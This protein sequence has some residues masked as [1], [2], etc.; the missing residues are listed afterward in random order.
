MNN[1]NEKIN[2]KNLN[3]L[4]QTARVILKLLLI[5]AICGIVIFGFVFL[6]KTQIINIL[7][8]VLSICSPLFIGLMI[9]WLFEPMIK[10]L[11]KRKLSRQLSTTIVYVL[12]IL[13]L[14]LLLVLV[15]P[16]FISQVKELIGQVPGY[17]V[18][19]KDFIGNF[20]AK[21][22]DSEIDINAIQNNVIAQVE[23]V[24]NNITSNSLSGI[25]DT[26]TKIISSGAVVALG[27]LIGFY[28]SLDFDKLT[29][30]INSWIPIKYKKDTGKVFDELNSM[31][32]GYV[33][34][35]LFTSLAVA[36]FTFIGLIISGIS[37]PL[38]FAIFCGI[39]NII[40]YFGPYIG[41][42]PTVLVGFSISPMCGIICAVTIILVQFID[43]NI[44]HPIVV[45]KATDIHP[46]TIVIGLLVFEYYFGIVGMILATPI[47]GAFK[48][49]FNFFN[50]KYHFIA[51]IKSPKKEEKV[52]EKL[53]E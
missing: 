1:K 26:V 2:Y 17:L 48:I 40:P 5:L 24:A 51:M 53:D 19:I 52:L 42:I 45:G 27:V 33:S 47:I 41:G 32:R 34:G 15:V 22:Q 44:V 20:F 35:T 25:I 36:F 29:M 10:S 13:I 31:A 12:F 18:K 50:E 23:K 3:A 39:T 14:I 38:L 8:T 16:E 28:F 6:E 9:A 7:L 11:E 21:F 43:G 30:R 4:I 46:I 37:S 49:L